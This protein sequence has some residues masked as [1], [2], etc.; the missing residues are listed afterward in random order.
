LGAFDGAGAGHVA[1]RIETAGVDHAFLKLRVT[2]S[3]RA[4]LGLEPGCT[5]TLTAG[6]MWRHNA[7]A[8][9]M[10][11]S[12]LDFAA[13]DCPEP[14][15]YARLLITEVGPNIPQSHD[16]VEL[17][18]VSSGTTKQLTV[19]EDASS[20]RT[21]ATFPDVAV[22]AGDI[23]VLHLN[24]EGDSPSSSERES[25]NE[26]TAPGAFPDAWDFI[27]GSAGLT[28]SHRVLMVKTPEGEV[29][30]A[31]AFVKSDIATPPGGFPDA[32]QAVQALGEWSPADCGGEACTYDSA[33]SVL[34]ICVD[35]K[36]AGNTRDSSMSRLAGADTDSKDD[37]VFN[38]T[39][40]TFGAPNP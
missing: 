18:V 13:I 24:P 40:A 12:A 35:W 4:E 2:E 38:E 37:W 9:P 22:E 19:V 32:V 3:L 39:G 36:D 34:D 10:G 28:F 21:L 23:I 8:Q 17:L 29:Q 7:T 31:V 30:D 26:S 6:P 11:F 27:G 1:A 15:D 25:K 16:L 14:P 33:I 20:P 5:V